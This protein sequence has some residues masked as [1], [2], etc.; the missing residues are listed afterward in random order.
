MIYTLDLLGTVTFAASGALLAYERR[1][2]YSVAVFYAF[3]TALGGGT[4]RDLLLHRPIFWI[5][6]PSYVW[7]ACTVGL[8][9]FGL[10]HVSPLHRKQLSIMDAIGMA[11]FTVIGAQIA[12]QS[13]ELVV[14]S[15]VSWILVPLMGTL[16]AVGGGTARDILSSKMPDVFKEPNYILVSILG[17]FLY[18]LMI[19]MQSSELLAAGITI[20]STIVFWVFACHYCDRPIRPLRRYSI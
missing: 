3:S 8:F 9:M 4:I 1:H 7:L 18:S 19:S 17:G 11:T 2:N 6:S 20:P 5:K 10:T 13:S 16:T 15:R 14:L 12:L